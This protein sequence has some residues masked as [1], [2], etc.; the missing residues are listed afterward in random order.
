[1]EAAI[2]NSDG[3]ISVFHLFPADSPKEHL[4][5]GNCWCRPSIIYQHPST[6]NEI[7]EHVDLQ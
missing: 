5:E 2:P 6:Q 7:W 1:M 4:H 3:G